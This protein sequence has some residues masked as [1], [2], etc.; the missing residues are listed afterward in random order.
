MASSQILYFVETSPLK[1]QI[2]NS[3]MDESVMLYNEQF[4]HEA[5]EAWHIQEGMCKP[6]PIFL[7]G[8]IH[9]KWQVMVRDN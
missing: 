5:D 3:Y 7:I 2:F 4:K 1:E 6:Y 8:H 9:N